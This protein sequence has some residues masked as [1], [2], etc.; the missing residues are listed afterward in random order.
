MPTLHSHNKELEKLLL[1]LNELDEKSKNDK[2]EVQKCFIPNEL[3]QFI[4]ENQKNLDI[5]GNVK[6][7]K[8]SLVKTSKWT[9]IGKDTNSQL[10]I[11]EY[12]LQVQTIKSDYSIPENLRLIVAIDK[13]DQVFLNVAK[14]G[15]SLHSYVDLNLE[16]I[17]NI[18][19]NFII[20]SLLNTDNIKA[21]LIDKNQILNTKK[22]LNSLS[23]IV[24]IRHNPA[25]ITLDRIS[26]ASSTQTSIKQKISL[27]IKNLPE[28][29]IAIHA[30]SPKDYKSRKSAF[31]DDGI[32][33]DSF[34]G[35][36]ER[37]A[38]NAKSSSNKNLVAIFTIYLNGKV[39]KEIR[40]NNQN[41][42]PMKDFSFYLAELVESFIR[43]DLN[44]T[45]YKIGLNT[46]TQLNQINEIEKKLDTLADELLTE[47]IPTVPPAPKAYPECSIKEVTFFSD[48]LIA[49]ASQFEEIIIKSQNI[50]KEYEKHLYSLSLIYGQLIH[51]KAAQNSNLKK[52]LKTT[53]EHYEI[54]FKNISTHINNLLVIFENVIVI[55]HSAHTQ[56]SFMNSL[57]KFKLKTNILKD[58]SKYSIKSKT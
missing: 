26:C 34:D 54:L 18:P 13:E 15:E 20:D 1:K 35:L 23:Q 19:D 39:Y 17:K 57:E 42:L 14:F 7:K 24:G 49:C 48:Q 58:L 43:K 31:D 37:L 53:F 16:L 36:I 27:E 44:S 50:S 21:T 12:Q 22:I 32:Y 56:S 47:S 5:L 9:P 28:I 41:P 4:G 45:K 40:G 2:Y 11:Y 30:F 29:T 3:S 46:V 51:S 52:S 8:M 10:N 25:Q 38:N 55:S 33:S 6:L